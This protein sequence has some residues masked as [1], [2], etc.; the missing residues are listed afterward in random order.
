MCQLFVSRV[1]CIALAEK[2]WLAEGWCIE[3]DWARL[4]WIVLDWAGLVNCIGLYWIGQ[5]LVCCATTSFCPTLCSQYVTG[6]RSNSSKVKQNYLPAAG[7]RMPKEAA[8]EKRALTTKQQGPLSGQRNWQ[9]ASYNISGVDTS[10]M[11]LLVNT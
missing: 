4:Y 7:K 5:W 1:C 8:T 6:D 2:L 10:Y 9:M 3:L 11:L